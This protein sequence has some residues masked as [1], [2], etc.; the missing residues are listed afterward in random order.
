VELNFDLTFKL[1]QAG[2]AR[3]PGEQSHGQEQKQNTLHWELPYDIVRAAS[4]SAQSDPWRA[5]DP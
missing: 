2:I 3:L 5:E 4:H 1:A